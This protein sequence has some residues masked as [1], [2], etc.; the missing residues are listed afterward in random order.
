[1]G[2]PFVGNGMIYGS[3]GVPCF[4]V[5][6]EEEERSLGRCKIKRPYFVPMPTRCSKTSFIAC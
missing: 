3:N 6:E 1:M 5:E 4:Y 2:I